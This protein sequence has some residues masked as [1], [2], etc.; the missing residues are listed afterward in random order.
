M[1]S[2]ADLKKEMQQS[3][4]ELIKAI[5]NFLKEMAQTEVEMMQTLTKLS[6]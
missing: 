3:L 2:L 5:V 1:Q 4:D 6:P